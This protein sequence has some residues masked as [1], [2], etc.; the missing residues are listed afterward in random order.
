MSWYVEISRATRLVRRSMI[1]MFPAVVI[2][3]RVCACCGSVYSEALLTY[4]ALDALDKGLLHAAL[5]LLVRS[6]HTALPVVLLYLTRAARECKARKREAML[7]AVRAITP[8]KQPT[9][10]KNQAPRYAGHSRLDMVTIPLWCLV[11]LLVRL[12]L[13]NGCVC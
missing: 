2:D 6:E 12:R 11:V 10:D 8:P 4:H 9:H 3:G 1:H 5:T 13:V 7:V